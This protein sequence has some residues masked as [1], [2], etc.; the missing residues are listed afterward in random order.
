MFKDYK[1][2]KFFVTIALILFILG[3]IIG[4][5]VIVEFIKTDYITKLPSAV[6][7]TGLVIL[8]VIVAQCGVILDTVVK[9]QKQRDELNLINYYQMENKNRR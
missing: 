8:S 6:L 7:A 5:P 1:P 2:F 3:L 9:H 4:S